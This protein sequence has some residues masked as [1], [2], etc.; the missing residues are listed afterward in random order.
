MVRPWTT[1][2]QRV[3]FHS[4][5][6]YE[7]PPSVLTLPPLLP[8]LNGVRLIWIPF[9]IHGLS[10][11]GPPA[12]GVLLTG[13]I[14]VLRFTLSRQLGSLDPRGLPIRTSKIW[15]CL[16]SGRQTPAPRGYKRT[17]GCSAP[18]PVAKSKAVSF[19]SLFGPRLASAPSNAASS[20]SAFNQT[21]G[22][23]YVP[24]SGMQA[25]LLKRPS[26]GE[27]PSL[28]A[29]LPLSVMCLIPVRRYCLAWHTS[30]LRFS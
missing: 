26:A 24:T 8:S 4:F 5:K 19:S 14:L 15:V 7:V 23:G 30:R 10:F 20:S 18:A 17:M 9:L 22:R 6:T 27:K 28:M 13:H 29:S 25:L 3:T 21:G 2:Q 11:E 16:A 12:R 1:S